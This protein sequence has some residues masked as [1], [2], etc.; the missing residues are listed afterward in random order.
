MRKILM[1]LFL[2]IFGITLVSCGD[3]DSNISY[4]E[5]TKEYNDS[6]ILQKVTIKD[7]DKNGNITV[8]IIQ[9]FNEDDEFEI[10]GS[11]P[12]PGCAR[13]W[14]WNCAYHQRKS[15]CRSLL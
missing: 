13:C 4:R 12:N 9:N 2:V 6:N 11:V 1:L 8:N 15:P 5:T 14:T 10:I 7:F 3:D